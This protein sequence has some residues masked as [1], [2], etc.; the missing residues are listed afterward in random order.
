MIHKKIKS[1]RVVLAPS[2]A[3]NPHAKEVISRANDLRAAVARE[4]GVPME[5]VFVEIVLTH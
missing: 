5:T 3:K 1:P 2:L 4:R